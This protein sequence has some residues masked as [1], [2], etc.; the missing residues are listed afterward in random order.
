MAHSAR[1]YYEDQPAEGE[2]LDS[3]KLVGMI[4]LEGW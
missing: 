3:D 2:D 1:Y 4:C